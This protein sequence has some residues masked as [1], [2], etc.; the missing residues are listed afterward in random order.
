MKKCLVLDLD[1]TLWGGIVG[2]DG[3][4][5]LALSLTAPGNSF[6]AFQQAIVDHYDRGVI[7][8]INSRNNEAD[9]MNVIRNHPNMILKEHHFAASRI[10]WEDKAQNIREL[11]NELNIGLDSMVFLDDDPTNR[12]LVRSLVPE[13]EVPELPESPKE[14]A[15]FLNGLP[16]FT[17]LV[18]TD[19]DKMRGNLYV[20][21]RL[22]KEEEKQHGTKEDFLK[23]LSLELS[24]YKNDTSCL[25]RL[26]QLTEKTNQ[27]NIAKHPLTEAE[28]QS[29]MESSE[30]EV[31]HGRL[32]DTFGD[33]GVIIFAVV[34]KSSETWHIE[35][36]LMSCRV[37]GRGVEDAFFSRI[38]KDAIEEGITSITIAYSASEKNAPAKEFIDKYF[39]NLSYAVGGNAIMPSWIHI[40]TYETI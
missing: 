10:N 13:V 36:L 15:R 3:M 5:G 17:S 11:A 28:I 16:Y 27:F 12:A 9:A 21:E 35:S 38:L 25:S 1:N 31:Y 39:T 32:Q 4:E 33:Y 19:E 29:Y 18:I 24:I 14:Y 26:S 20:T 7:L 30:Y 2:E 6:I 8:A 34:K 40:P 37:F 22:R 23:G